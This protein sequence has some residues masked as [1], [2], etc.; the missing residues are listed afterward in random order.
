[1][2]EQ[3]RYRVQVQ[4]DVYAKSDKA[5]AELIGDTIYNIQD[6]D[7]NKVI[8]FSEAPFAKMNHREI[9]YDTLNRKIMNERSQELKDHLPF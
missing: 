1:M 9:D 8:Y 7:N 5:A 6:I 3:K 4:F 2:T